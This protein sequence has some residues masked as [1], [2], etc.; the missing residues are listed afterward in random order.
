ML[1]PGITADLPAELERIIQK[2]LEKQPDHRYQSAQDLVV[3][4]Q[5]LQRVT[6]AAPARLPE[7]PRHNL[8][9]ELTGFVGRRKE[10]AQLQSMLASSRLV[11]LTGA[12][13]A[14]KTRLAVRLAY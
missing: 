12:G 9:A 4:L 1:S 13:G 11:S 3:D 2:C 5:A 10:L 14:G 8:P 6:H 7:R